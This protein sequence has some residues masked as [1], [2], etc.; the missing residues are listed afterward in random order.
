MDILID[1]FKE[2]IST[3]SAN[4]AIMLIMVVFMIVGGIDKIRGNKK[5]YGER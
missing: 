2:Y 5:G 1:S 3:F 4:K